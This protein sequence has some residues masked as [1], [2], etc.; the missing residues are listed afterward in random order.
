MEHASA[1]ATKEGYP[2]PMSREDALKHRELL[3]E[4]RMSFAI[5]ATELYERGFVFHER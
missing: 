3:M 1:L 4:E 2:W 5:D